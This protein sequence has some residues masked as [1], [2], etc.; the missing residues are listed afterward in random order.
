MTI[1]TL[2]PEQIYSPDKLDL[3]FKKREDIKRR[4]LDIV[5]TP[6]FPRDTRGDRNDRDNRM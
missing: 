1:K 3:W 2:L 4:F 6:V 5:G